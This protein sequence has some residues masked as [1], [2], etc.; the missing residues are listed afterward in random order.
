MC[1]LAPA[2]FWPVFCPWEH[3]TKAFL[4]YMMTGVVLGIVAG[5]VGSRLWFLAA[6]A[7]AFSLMLGVSTL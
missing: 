2:R 3:S 5:V 4:L 1:I 6:L 7:A